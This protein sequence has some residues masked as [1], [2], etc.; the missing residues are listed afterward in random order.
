MHYFPKEFMWGSSTN[1]Q[2][3]EGGRDVNAVGVSIADVR[4][5]PTDTLTDADFEKFKVGADH[6]HHLEEDI[7]LYGE[8]GFQMY[9]FT[10]AWTRIFPTGE[11]KEPNQEGFAFYDKMLDKLEEYHIVPVATF[12]AYDEPQQLSEKHQG[13][14]DRAIVEKYLRYVRACVK[15]FKGRIKYYIPFNEQNCAQQDSEYMTGYACKTE[16]EIL[17]MEHNFALAWAQATVIIHEEDPEAKTGG[18]LANCVPYPATCNPADIEAADKRMQTF[19]WAYTDLF[20]RKK[21]SPYFLNRFSKEC[22]EKVILSGD[23][24]ILAAAEPDFLSLTYYTSN[25]I[26]AENKQQGAYH[27]DL[28]TNPYTEHTKWKWDIDPY[29]FKHYLEEFWHAYEMPIL[30]TE[31]GMGDYD[32]VTQDGKIYDDARINYLAQHIERMGEA[33]ENGVKIIGYLTW[34]ATDLYSTREG[35]NKR[36][37][38]IHVDENTME[39]KKKKSFYWYQRVIQTNGKVLGA[40]GLEY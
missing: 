8:M 10:I 2:Q 15:H 4:N 31:N 23:L 3:F 25:L 37:G 13:W 12:Y 18:N 32:T 7:D 11:E 33:M 35:L 9:R 6:Y 39:R 1:A 20:C 24:E 28:P 36:Y 19:G 21:Y 16:E 40:D 34:S 17:R 5:M 22:R 29:G 26:S 27:K 38:F 14:V 30:I